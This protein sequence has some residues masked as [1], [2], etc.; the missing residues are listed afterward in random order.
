MSPGDRLTV[1]EEDDQ[2]WYYGHNIK[3]HAY[4]RYPSN[5][6]KFP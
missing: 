1:E 6:V 3:T 5:Y 2:G 4:G